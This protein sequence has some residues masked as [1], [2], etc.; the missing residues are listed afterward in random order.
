MSS[1]G[2]LQLTLTLRQVL[3]KRA[4]QLWLAR[5]LWQAA[6]GG[7]QSALFELS[8]QGQFT[9]T[10]GWEL[11]FFCTACPCGDACLQAMGAGGSAIALLVADQC[12]QTAECR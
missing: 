6:D 11:H 9:K 2:T 8:P 3:A 7:T 10:P 5:Q 12:A 1:F 4:L